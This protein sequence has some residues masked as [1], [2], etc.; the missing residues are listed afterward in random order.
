MPAVSSIFVPMREVQNNL[1]K[2]ATIS[3]KEWKMTM[4]RRDLTKMVAQGGAAAAIIG[5]SSGSAEETN[6]K[7]AVI[8]HAAEAASGATK[9]LHLFHGSGLHHVNVRVRDMDRAI[10]FYEQ[11]FGFRLLFRWDGVEAMNEGGIY[12]RNPLQGAHLDIGDG[13][14]LELIPAP[15]NAIPPDDRASSFNHIGLRVSDLEQTYTQ[16]LAAGAKP[17][18]IKDGSGGVWEG[19]TEIKLKAKPPFGRSFV[20]RA[21]HILGPND[22]IIELFEA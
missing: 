8:S 6:N 11:S 12:F 20:V 16:A 4:L 19:P 15:E 18:P 3:R 2:T 13:Q 9:P 21:A 14:I 5:V 22:E 10:D 1:K 17:F 7:P